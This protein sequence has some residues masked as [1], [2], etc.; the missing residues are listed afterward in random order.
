MPKKQ[1]D[2]VELL[3]LPAELVAAIPCPYMIEYRRPNTNGRVY[4]NPCGMQALL[5]RY[6]EPYGYRSRCE[7][8]HVVVLAATQIPGLWQDLKSDTD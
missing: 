2:P 7:E 1:I 6:Q 8:G 4:G 3:K 5:Y